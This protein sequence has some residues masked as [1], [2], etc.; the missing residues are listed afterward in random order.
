MK[1]IKQYSSTFG[2]PIFHPKV[3]QNAGFSMQDFKN[4]SMGYTP[5]PHGRRRRF[6]LHLPQHGRRSAV[7]RAPPAPQSVTAALF[8]S[9]FR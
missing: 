9:C 8:S 7:G 6:L 4:I 2:V 1:N 5:S 3:N